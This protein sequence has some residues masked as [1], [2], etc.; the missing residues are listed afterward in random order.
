[1]EL[2]PFH[3]L[4]RQQH[5]RRI[6]SLTLLSGSD[7]HEDGCG[8]RHRESRHAD[9]IHNPVYSAKRARAESG[10]D[11]FTAPS[12]TRRGIVSKVG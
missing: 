12:P 6:A 9:S 7:G 8:Q 10:G 11:N 2:P 4:A 3:E 1:M 5:A